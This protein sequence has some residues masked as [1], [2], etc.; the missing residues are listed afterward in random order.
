MATADKLW[1]ELGVRDEVSKVL[2]NLI[3]NADKLAMQMTD[4]STDT[5]KNFYK[6][7]VDIAGVFDK[8]HV[9]QKRISDAM[10]VTGDRDEKKRLRTI[11]KELEGLEKKYN[12]LSK[13]PDSM[14]MDGYAALQKNKEAIDLLIKDTLRYV[15]G[16]EAKERAEA[17]NAANEEKRI[18]SMKA[19]YYELQ[20]YRK[21]LSDAI[22][23]AAPGTDLTDATS[24]INSIS[25][26]M[27][28]VRRAQANG[29]GLPSSTTG[30]DYEE[31]LRRVKAQLNALTGATNDYNSKLETNKQ[32]QATLNR[33]KDDAVSQQTIAGIRKQSSEYTALGRKI[34]EITDLIHR[35][36]Y[37]QGLLGSGRLATPT[38]TKDKV[39]EE[40]NA[41]QRR[42][43]ENLATGRQREIEDAAA[44][45]QK[46]AA[47]RKAME[48]VS[49]LA[50]V[51][52]GLISSYNRVAEAGSQANR[53]TV[54][55]QNQIGAYA[56]LYGLERI[57][58]SIVT[59][60]GQFEVQH[61]AL[62]NI[63][64]DVQ[65]ANILF[66]QLKELAIESPKTFM[67]LT[68]YAK[69]LSAYQIPANE[70][71]DTTKRLADMSSGLGVDMNRLILAY[72]QVRSAAVL[73]GQELRQFTEAGIPMV[74]ALADKFTQLNGKLTTTADVF[75]LISARAVPFEMVKEVLWDMT[76][77]GGQF[78]NMQEELANTLYGKWQK[79][80]DSWQIM[81]GSIAE[82]TNVSG[83][84]FKSLLDIVVA[85]T[86]NLDKMVP[87]LAA[88]G[89]AKGIS[90]L[91]EGLRNVYMRRTGDMAIKNMEIAK[92]KEANRLERERIWSG[93]QLSAAELELVKNKNRLVS[94]DYQILALEN[95]ISAKKAHQ[96]MLDGQMSKQHFYRYLQMQG[97]TR[98]QRKQIALGNLQALQQGPN[99]TPMGKMGS[100]L[101]VGAKGALSFFGGWIGV[102]ITAIGSLVSLYEYLDQADDR[103]NDL[104]NSI[105]GGAEQN[106]NQ[107]ANTLKTV[108]NSTDEPFK[109]VEALEEALLGMGV[110]GKQVV[111]DSRGFDDM[112]ERLQNLTENAKAYQ[113]ALEAMGTPQGK[114]AIK[115][116][117]DKSDIND[118]MEEYEDLQNIEYKRMAALERYSAKYQQ[119]IDT[120]K[121]KHKELEEQL[122]ST[123]LY[124]NIRK[125]MTGGYANE[126]VG[127]FASNTPWGE[128]ITD[129][130]KAVEESEE[131]LNNIKDKV[132]P[133]AMDMLKSLARQAGV[134]INKSYEELTDAEKTKLR[135]IA[136]NFAN[137]LEK[138]SQDAK[139]SIASWVAQGF[140]AQLYLTPILNTN[141]LT[142]LPYLLDEWQ[143]GKGYG[144]WSKNDLKDANTDFLAFSKKQSQRKVDLENKIKGYDTQLAG[145]VLDPNLI[146]TIQGQRTA[147]QNELD[148]LNDSLK[149]GQWVF[150]K[151]LTK[152]NKTG[153]NKK[154]TQLEALKNRIDLYKKF[155]QEL[156]GYKNIYSESEALDIL[157]K[158]GEFSAVFEMRDVNGNTLNNLA[159][160]KQTLDQL[161]DGFDANTEARQKLINSTKA[162]IENKQRKDAVESIKVYVSELQKM[163]SVM[164]ENYQ[165]YKKWVDLTG[166][167]EL[168]ARIAG[169]AQNTTY[170]DYLRDRM[171][172]ELSKSARNSSLS[173]DDVLGY[174]AQDIQ[175]FGKESAIVS[176]WEE[177]RKNQ[178]QLKKEQLELYA[179]AI[180]NAKTYE[181][182]IADINRQLEK[183][184]EAIEA[185]GGD[186]NLIR[187]ARR[188]AEKQISSIQWEKFKEENN[189]GEVFGDIGSMPLNRIKKM[190]SAMQDL[191]ETTD[192][193]VV[194]TKA[195]Y[196]AMEKLMNQEA[197]LNPIQAISSAIK[198]YDLTGKKI[199][200]LEMRRE[201]IRRGYDTS[202]TESELDKSIDEL[203]VSQAK[204]LRDL[205]KAIKALS[206]NITSLGNSFETLGNSIGGTFGDV[207]NGFG[208]IFG[209]LGKSMDAITSVDVNAEGIAAV[210]GEV[211]AVVAVFSAMIDMN[212]KLHEL[213]PST[214]SLYEYY[215]EKQREINKAREAIDDY[216]VA[217]IKSAQQEK[218]W[219]YKNEL[220]DIR[221]GGFVQGKLLENYL[222]TALAPQVIYEES[223]SGLS[224]WAGAIIG[225]IVGAV[226]TIVTWGSGGPLGVAAGT[227]IANIIG[228]VAATAV[229]AA[230]ATGAG[231]AI[232]QA[233][234]AAAEAILYKEGET[235]ARANMRIQHHHASFWRGEKTQ[236]LE[237]WVREEYGKELFG[238]NFHGYDLIDLDIAKSILDRDI[239][240]AGETKETLE[241]LV[242]LTEQIKEVQ[243]QAHQYVSDRFSPLVDNMTDSLWDWLKDGTNML[244][245]FRD[246]ASDTFAEIAK[247]AIKAFLKINLM[248]KF[249]SPLNDM[250]E[251][252]S[253]GLIDETALML[254]VANVAGQIGETFATLSPTLM[255]MGKVLA[256]A[257]K[258]E[259]YD[260]VNGTQGSSSS[261]T[262]TIKGMSEGTADII[263]GYINS[264][265]ADVSVNRTMIANYYPQFLSSLQRGNTIADSQ[266]AQLRTIVEN[267]RQ[268][269]EFVE[270]IYNILHGVAPDG[271]RIQV[272]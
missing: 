70:L 244:R 122:T 124:E 86:Q 152:G 104:A 198:N 7:M 1:F 194:N 76:S 71:Y 245:S 234:Q 148:Q 56:G 179:E 252:Y 272:K 108:E 24:L 89:T 81:L 162:D 68:S 264:I 67:E 17:T 49:A 196:E 175:K 96:L 90:A 178:N 213:L 166:N 59:I 140:Y 109:K 181:D 182:K 225:A 151:T 117:L 41:I 87:L 218:D 258:L 99:P 143:K 113:E 64:G 177:W 78:Y 195:W 184:I 29:S 270:R 85:L 5:L 9:T 259:G 20:R 212:K 66:G 176:I 120:M 27:S 129:Y 254:G 127:Y 216:A 224:K 136:T 192:L 110:A 61:V 205:Q 72:G 19:K 125:L 43:N 141:E 6:N 101:G 249:T 84:M 154:D 226:I 130:A 156:Q 80:Q 126:A 52:D 65:Q 42:Y 28:A 232:G 246:Y 227:A 186:E 230:V 201:A 256:D 123:N 145:T 257:F 268:N 75:K 202:M 37:E 63:L 95:Q 267:T 83:Y 45:T 171:Q 107:L 77:Q 106:A 47:T 103:L 229:G 255:E 220:T 13:M 217:V 169:V 12:K 53:I 214:E 243:D 209:G 15:D 60:G 34:Q 168:A 207:L 119:M 164:S 40:L 94:S 172:E 211:G 161:T 271:M 206:N 116:A 147:L 131:H 208:T 2:E 160:Y 238:W 239:T 134:D 82:G 111:Q 150:D 97:Y 112:S 240:L 247:D 144:L 197:V 33:L 237:E 146:P 142:G 139:D 3:K 100:L 36:N 263:V 158:D 102:A 11:S 219:L 261:S 233:M 121:S 18:D 174:S 228:G 241:R 44:K 265:R 93:R 199:G 187:N 137:G 221:N 105:S 48:A 135:T 159:N 235:S 26:R 16:I 189:W 46:S 149:E 39:T 188:N 98:E 180:K 191:A 223:R 79:L 51:N 251:A 54:Q 50:H 132:I 133:D 269:R 183:E 38:Y 155:Y 23:N 55:F 242:E 73:R 167:Q 69:Q 35:V 8:I 57:L 163:M 115:E 32:I 10:T 153:G 170:A 25:G 260:I 58:K 74:Q 262:S 248:D 173:A 91:S 138:G 231:A 92:L 185:M 193:N 114:A 62:Q 200:E 215:A 4:I 250:F 236:N 253:F 22:V 30:A 31:F 128:A 14:G 88:I 21:Q 204:S 203:K 266:L 222:N 157:R 210:A 165:T 118:E 190:V